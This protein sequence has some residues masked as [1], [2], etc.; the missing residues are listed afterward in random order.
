MRVT[1]RGLNPQHGPEVGIPFLASF[2][3]SILFNMSDVLM[4]MPLEVEGHGFGFFCFCYDMEDAA[5]EFSPR[6]E[7]GLGGAEQD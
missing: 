3:Y 4:I 2:S 7:L 6:Q 1:E 5:V